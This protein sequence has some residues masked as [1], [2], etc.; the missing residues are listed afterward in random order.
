MNF[1]GDLLDL[2]FGLNEIR[3]YFNLSL[4]DT[5][6]VVQLDESSDLCLSITRGEENII[7]Q[8]L[9]KRVAQ[10]VAEAVI[11]TAKE[12]GVARI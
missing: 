6:K 11:K 1:C 5:I 8:A 10:A 9:D 7:A 12:T 2:E 4:A 3:N